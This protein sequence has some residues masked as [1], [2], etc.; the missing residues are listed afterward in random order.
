[1]KNES[2]NILSLAIPL[3]TEMSTLK[4]LSLSLDGHPKGFFG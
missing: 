4:K 3:R 1:M 2:G